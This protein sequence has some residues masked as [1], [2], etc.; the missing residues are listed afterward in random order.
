M[1]GTRAHGEAALSHA[2]VGYF[3]GVASASLRA[4]TRFYWWNLAGF[5]QMQA[6]PCCHRQPLRKPRHEFC[7]D[8]NLF[9]AVGDAQP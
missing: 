4:N 7:I 5:F 8:A 6:D 2:R 3:H 1:P 9:A